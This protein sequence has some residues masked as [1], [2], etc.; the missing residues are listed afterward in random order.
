M[1]DEK[2]GSRAAAMGRRGGL[3]GGK[4]RA[5]AL[6]PEQL[7]ASG[8]KA[9]QARWGPKATHLGSLPIVGLAIPCANLDN[10]LRVISQRG[11]YS[12]IG[13]SVPTSGQSGRAGDVPSFLAA[14]NLQPFISKELRAT[15]SRPI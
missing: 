14:R 2:K 13:G 8:E 1:V 6:T 15:V 4:A 5:A 11:F 9:A 7:R 10:G 12:V 3:K